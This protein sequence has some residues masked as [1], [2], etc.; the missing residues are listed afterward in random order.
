MF[1]MNQVKMTGNDE[2]VTLLSFRDDD[3][4]NH[5]LSQSFYLLLGSILIFKR[6]HTQIKGLL[7]EKQIT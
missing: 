5:N 2:A 4:A 3:I 6:F 1:C 7:E